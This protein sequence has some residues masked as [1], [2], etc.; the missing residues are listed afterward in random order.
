MA[1][2]DR[3]SLDVDRLGRA[4]DLVARQVAD[5][6][7]TYAALA[8][9][10]GD[11]LV[12]S[13]AFHGDREL[14]PAPRSLIASITKPITATAVL[15][16]VEAG[17]LVLN[18]PIT[19]YIPEFAPQR[20]E[21]TKHATA[22]TPWHVLTHTAGL[23]DAPDAFFLRGVPSPAT[24]LERI[25]HDPLRFAPGTAYAYTSDSFYLLS[26]LIERAS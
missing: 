3:P 6:R 24:M 16:L 20:A 10:R 14:D 4:F 9:A 26:A 5:E 19:T 12:R 1:P 22:I 7:A 11:G 17:A 21:G 25:C 23:T 8:V 18:E 15:Q 2:S 13:A